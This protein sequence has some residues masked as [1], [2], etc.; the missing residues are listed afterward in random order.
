MA[1]AAGLEMRAE[2]NDALWRRLYYFFWQAANELF[3][4]LGFL[5]GDFFAWNY[6]G[7]EDGGAFVMG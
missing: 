1:A 3:L 4:S 5:D 6:V 2:G 7:D